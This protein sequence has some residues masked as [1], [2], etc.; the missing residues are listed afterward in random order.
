MIFWFSELGS[1][2]L[3]D[4]WVLRPWP[5]CC[6]IKIWSLELFRSYECSP[7]VFYS[8]ISRGSG[9]VSFANVLAF[10]RW[11]GLRNRA[12][13]IGA[14]LTSFIWS[15]FMFRRVE[16]LTSCIVTEGIW[17]MMSAQFILFML[18]NCRLEQIRYQD[19][20]REKWR[21][22]Y[23]VF[24]FLSTHEYDWFSFQIFQML[25]ALREA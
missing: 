14:I 9:D 19:A 6:V 25:S 24:L 1:C 20:L 8:E 7:D 4:G 12:V 18:S 10:L 3:A 15:A 2:I 22:S 11:L 13:R 5:L 23:V 17:N 16:N 21:N